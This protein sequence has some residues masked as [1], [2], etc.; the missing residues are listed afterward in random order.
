MVATS[1]IVLAK[2]RQSTDW[3]WGKPD[4][5]G[6]GDKFGN[7]GS[8]KQLHQPVGTRGQPVEEADDMKVRCVSLVGG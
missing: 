5:A 1:G 8:I 4:S 7:G 2:A 6:N 3:W